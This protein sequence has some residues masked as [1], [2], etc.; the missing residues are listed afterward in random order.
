MLTHCSKEV[1]VDLVSAVDSTQRKAVLSG[2]WLVIFFFVMD[3]SGNYRYQE[4][5]AELVGVG[6]SA[7]T[8]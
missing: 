4:M 1:I 5:V 3:K 8:L 7:L 2:F 6:S